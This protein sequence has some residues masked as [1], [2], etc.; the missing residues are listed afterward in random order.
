M[1]SRALDPLKY[2]HRMMI[3]IG[4]CQNRAVLRQHEEMRIMYAG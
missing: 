3:H 1:H 2:R 4:C